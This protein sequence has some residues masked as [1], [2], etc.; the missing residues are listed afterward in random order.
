MFQGE[1]TKKSGFQN[2]QTKKKRDEEHKKGSQTLTTCSDKLK[3]NPALA[4]RTN[5]VSDDNELAE[6]EDRCEQ[7]Q[8]LGHD[9][10]RF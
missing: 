8:Q 1:K 7:E 5:E 3:R 10:I 2:R 9:G 6:K 4:K